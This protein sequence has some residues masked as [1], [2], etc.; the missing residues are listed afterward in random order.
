MSSHTLLDA[1]LA[2]K[3]QDYYA[4]FSAFMTSLLADNASVLGYAL[5]TTTSTTS[6][7]IGSGS[8]TLIMASA[9]PYGVGAFVLVARTADPTNTWMWGTV[10]AVSSTSL[11][12]NVTVTAGA[13]G[14]YTDWT[15]TASGPRGATGATGGVSS[16]NGRTGTV[17]L[18]ESDLAS[19]GL[20]FQIDQ[21]SISTTLA[22]SGAKI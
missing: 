12:V 22:A 6:M 2:K 4:E 13:G 1:L 14:P 9:L 10:T 16:V 20:R 11:T 17:T 8:K 15:L 7:S 5:G 19:L 18:Q 3:G 21:L